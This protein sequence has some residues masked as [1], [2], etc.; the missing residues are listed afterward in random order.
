MTPGLGASALSLVTPIPEAPERRAGPA[1]PG[2]ACDA[3][4]LAP[5]RA[6]VR[7]PVVD[8]SLPSPALPGAWL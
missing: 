3:R 2:G 7:C 1:R 6:G 4:A 8:R 5:G